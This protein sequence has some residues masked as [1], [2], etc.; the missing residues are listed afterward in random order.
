MARCQ[1]RLIEN[2]PNGN[3]INLLIMAMNN[4]L[5]DTIQY[6]L[7]VSER[8]NRSSARFQSN[9]IESR[10]PGVWNVRSHSN[11]KSFP[12]LI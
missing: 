9:I 6:R 2:N 7:F 12:K 1:N 4:F 5:A 10:Y 3:E 8:K 11:E